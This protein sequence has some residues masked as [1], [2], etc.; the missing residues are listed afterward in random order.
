M[1]SLNFNEG[2]KEFCINNDETRVI[3]FNPTDLSMVDRI[4][5]TQ[6]AIAELYKEHEKDD[7]ET[8]RKL[9][10]EALKEGIN[11]IFNIDCYDVI[12]GN[13]NPLSPCNGK[14][15]YE[16]MFEGLIKLVK[17]YLEEER[18]KLEKQSALYIKE[19]RA[20]AKNR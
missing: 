15:L 10:K 1:Q 17:P 16:R 19:A 4:E 11:Y 7:S 20:N 9:L 13:Q 8:L 14:C 3:R 6:K 12:F 2:Y 5:E 18:K